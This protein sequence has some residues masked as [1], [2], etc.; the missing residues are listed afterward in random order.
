MVMKLV[1]ALVCG[2]FAAVSFGDSKIVYVSP[3]GT[4]DGTSPE[5]PSTFV[6]AMKKLADGDTM[7]FLDGDYTAQVV[8]FSSNTGDGNRSGAIDVTL[9]GN[10]DNPE[11]SK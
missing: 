11:K 3:D 2:T 6:S 1:L 7:K 4:G 8:R 5:S 9:E 10:V